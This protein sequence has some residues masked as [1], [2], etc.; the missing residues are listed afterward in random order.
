[1]SVLNQAAAQRPPKAAMLVAQRIVQDAL[2]RAF[3]RA[4]CSPPR[5]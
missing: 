4:T 2:G 1:M 3:A 5:R